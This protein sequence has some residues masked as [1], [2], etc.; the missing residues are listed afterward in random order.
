MTFLRFPYLLPQ[1]GLRLASKALLLTVI[2]PT[3]L[4]ELGLLALFV[5]RHL[6]FLMVI[7][8]WAVSPPRFGNIHLKNVTLL[9]I[10]KCISRSRME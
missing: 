1:D 6:K 3:A 5:L 2:T 8:A 10:R 9:G 7:A 4:S